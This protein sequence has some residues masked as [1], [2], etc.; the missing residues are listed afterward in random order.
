MI[1]DYQGGAST[2][3]GAIGRHMTP[4]DALLRQSSLWFVLKLLIPPRDD[5]NE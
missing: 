4:F 2:T 3:L 1:R 5:M